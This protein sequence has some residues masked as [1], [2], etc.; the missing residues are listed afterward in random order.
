MLDSFLAMISKLGSVPP[1]R[2]RPYSNGVAA[3]PKCKQCSPVTLLGGG[4]QNIYSPG[5]SRKSLGTTEMNEYCTES[6][7]RQRL[8]TFESFDETSYLKN[9]NRGS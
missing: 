6:R 9:C 7:Q 2:A 8:T 4:L 5:S 3:P 1:G